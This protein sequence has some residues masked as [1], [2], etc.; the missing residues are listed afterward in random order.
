MRRSAKVLIGAALVLIGCTGCSTPGGPVDHSI[1][2]ETLADVSGAVSGMW[3]EPVAATGK[4]FEQRAA[5]YAAEGDVQAEIACW[6]F[7]TRLDPQNPLYRDRLAQLRS[8]VGEAAERHYRLA[9][10]EIKRKNI[11]SARQHLLTALRLD[12][13][14]IDALRLLKRLSAVKATRAYRVQPGDTPAGIAE[15]V[16]G[17]PTKGFLIELYN[18]LENGGKLS[19]G[20][21]LEL[22]LLAPHYIKPRPDIDQSIEQAKASFQKHDYRQ[23]LS[24]TR[25][26]LLY[27]PDNS[28]AADLKNAALYETAAGLRRHGKYAE[29]LKALRQVDSKYKG[30]QKDIAELK[31][32]IAEEAE[33]YYRIGVNHYVNEEFGSAIENWKKTLRLNPKHPKARKDIENARRLLQKLEKVD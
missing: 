28:E 24:L 33:K 23:V 17:D 10:T 30:V 5:A 7:L 13:D 21:V 2:S 25:E 3:G 22:P 16:Y 1:G 20:R 29:A 12:P 18:D 32:L 6:D 15:K 14:R 27:D 8:A 19:D 9:Q 31:A 4:R 26:I 11:Q